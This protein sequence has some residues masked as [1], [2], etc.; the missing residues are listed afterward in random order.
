MMSSQFYF[1]R[2]G[3]QRSQQTFADLNKH[4][5][6]PSDSISTLYDHREQVSELARYLWKKCFYF[7]KLT[8][9]E[10]SSISN[11]S[12]KLF[13]IS[14]I[15]NASKALLRKGN[16]DPVNL[17]KMEKAAEFWTIV[18]ENMSDWN[19][20]RERKVASHELR[21]TM[22]HAHGVILQ[23]LGQIGADLL[24]RHPKN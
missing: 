10:R 9:T 15:K 17:D 3:L 21:M 2:R 16:R 13:T 20:A 12:T 8:E 1:Y 5:V 18:T 6:R 19:A 24:I 22:V 23:A 7:K 11:R 4:A 14:S